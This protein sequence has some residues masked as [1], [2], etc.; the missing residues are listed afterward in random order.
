MAE[1]DGAKANEEVAEAERLKLDME[2]SEYLAQTEKDEALK[3]EALAALDEDT[4]AEYFANS[5]RDETIGTEEEAS[6]IIAQTQAEELLGTSTGEELSANS[7]RV[8]AE[9]K[10][11]KAEQLMK[12]SLAH[13]TH[14]IGFALQSLVTAGLVIYVVVMRFLFHSAVPSIKRSFTPE[15]QFT[16]LDFGEKMLLL[17]MH[18]TVVMGTVTLLVGRLGFISVAI[19]S[20]LKALAVLAS[21]AGLIESAG[22]HSL[23]EACCGLMNGDD[24]ITTSMA[25]AISFASNIIY[26]VPVVLMECL[27]LLSVFGPTVF[28]QIHNTLVGNQVLLLFALLLV[29]SIRI[30]MFKR[31]SSAKV[32][33][34]KHESELESGVEEGYFCCD[35]RKSLSAL[36][37]N[38]LDQE[39][40]SMEEIALLNSTKS[41]EVKSRSVSYGEKKSSGCYQMFCQYWKSLQMPAD[42][43]VCSL[44][45]MQIYHS[46]P[47]LRVLEPVSKSLL[48][49]AASLHLPMLLSVI[50]ILLLSVHL[51]FVR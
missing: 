26:L 36:N 1:E 2:E 46:L 25:M 4:A 11:A 31:I 24:A 43:L 33:Q 39:Y 45:A 51:M 6:S 34:T 41:I 14:A 50:S 21:A 13:G 15:L 19:T 10:E 7:M 9:S 18:F 49:V 42:L 37:T 16:I 30:I 35:E 29:F 44:M 8:D 3:D 38:E 47:L 48:G 32:D 17:A 22:I 28:D 20:S 23:T 40:G 27:I 5:A 12:G